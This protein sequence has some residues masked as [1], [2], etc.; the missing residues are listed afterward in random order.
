MGE[1]SA[2]GEEDIREEEGLEK[3]KGK[4]TITIKMPKNKEE[5]KIIFRGQKRKNPETHPILGIYQG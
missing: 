2:E 3:K 5:P 1:E 4:K